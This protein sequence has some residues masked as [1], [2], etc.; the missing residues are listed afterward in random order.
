MTSQIGRVRRG[1]RQGY[2]DNRREVI[3]GMPL[4]EIAGDR[5]RAS[6]PRAVLC[7]L[8][9]RRRKGRGARH[10]GAIRGSARAGL[11]CEAP[12]GSARLELGAVRGARGVRVS[13]APRPHVTTISSNS[14]TSECS[15][16]FTNVKMLISCGAVR[17]GGGRT[18]MCGLGRSRVRSHARRAAVGLLCN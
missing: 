14:R 12:L 9:R 15:L 5:D 13:A 7:R 11:P 17:A 2:A 3:R 10:A 1:P 16:S 18:Y 4:P 6:M 8:C